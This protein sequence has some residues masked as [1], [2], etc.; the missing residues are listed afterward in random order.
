[1]IMRMLCV[2]WWKPLEGFSLHSMQRTTE[3][4]YEKRIMNLDKSKEALEERQGRGE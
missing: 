2:G 3:H 4:I 1:M